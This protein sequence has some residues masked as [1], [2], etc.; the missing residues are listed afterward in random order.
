MKSV[1]TPIVLLVSCYW[2]VFHLWNGRRVK[3]EFDRGGER[4]DRALKVDRTS[5][6]RPGILGI[7]QN[8]ELNDTS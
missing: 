1:A 8:T 3:A 4:F 6:D 5:C 2:H 7:G